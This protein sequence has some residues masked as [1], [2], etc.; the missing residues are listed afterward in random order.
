MISINI[1]RGLFGR[2]DGL[3]ARRSCCTTPVASPVVTE[4]VR[5]NKGVGVSAQILYTFAF[6][7]RSR[8][9]D[10]SPIIILFLF[11][12]SFFVI[13]Y[14]ILYSFLY[15]LYVSVFSTHF[16]LSTSSFYTYVK[17]DKL[18]LLIKNLK[19]FYI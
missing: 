7:F 16:S 8:K 2:Q 15:P 6:L 3:A 5:Q 14:L 12:F 19:Y 18:N 17:R 9:R 11:N 4:P 1:W 10:F 13:I